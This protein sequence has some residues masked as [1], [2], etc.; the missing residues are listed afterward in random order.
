MINDGTSN[1]ILV[2]ES[3]GECH[4]HL[5]GWWYWDGMGAAHA[6]TV[7]P[8]NDPTTCHKIKG[9]QKPPTAGPDCSSPGEHNYSW[10]FKSRHPG[11]CNLLFCD[12]SVDFINES[13]DHRSYQAMGGR[14]DGEVIKERNP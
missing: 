6:S 13:I 7:V 3:L 12:G 1:T 9:G 14:S 11:G 4:S 10:G 5:A 2:G 8:I